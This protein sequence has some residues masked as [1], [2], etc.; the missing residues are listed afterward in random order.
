M[1]VDSF[2]MACP[3]KSLN[4]C[5]LTIWNKPYLK[6]VKSE[7]NPLLNTDHLRKNATETHFPREKANYIVKS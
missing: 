7:H 5:P 2:C 6:Q 4:H 1:Y 3:L